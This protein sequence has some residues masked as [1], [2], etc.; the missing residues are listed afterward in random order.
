MLVRSCIQAIPIH[1]V[2]QRVAGGLII[3]YGLDYNIAF[4]PL[5]P[6]GDFTDKNIVVSD[7]VKGNITLRL[8]SVPWDQALDIVLESKA[9]AMRSNGNVIWVA[10]ALELQAKEQQELQALQRKK[11]LE[12]LVTEYIAVNFAKAE[13]MI[14]LIQKNNTADQRNGSGSMLSDRGS[15]LDR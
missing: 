12:P 5:R 13:E 11:A 3:S 10:P 14:K 2:Q 1:G 15:V 9:L 6:L 7:S 4:I 8:K